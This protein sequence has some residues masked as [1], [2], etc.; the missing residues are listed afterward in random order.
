MKLNF[1]FKII[2][3]ILFLLPKS[4]YSINPPIITA[5]GNQNYCAGTS[6]KIVETISIVNDPS[7]TDAEAIYIQISSGYIN[8]QDELKLANY[9]AHPKIITSW[10]S[11]AGK[12]KL[13]S[14]SGTKILYT[15]FVSAIKDIEYSNSSIAPSGIRNFSITIGQ[16]NYLPSTGHYYQFIKSI[17]ISWTDAKIAA[18]ANPYYGLKGYLATLLTLEEAKLSGEQSSGAGWIGGS[19]AATEGIWKWVTGPE[20]GTIFWNGTGDGSTPNFAYWN[21][22]GNEPNN[23]G[24]EDYAHITA[25]GVGTPGSWNDL[26]NTGSTSGDYQPKGYI[27]EYGGMPG[28]PIL[29]IS[30]STTI[31]I[32]RI[33]S[34]T[35][36]SICNSG[37][38]TLQAT[39]S[40]GNVYWYT[41]KAGGM[42]IATGNSYSTP[43]LSTT[44]FYYV[45]A[46]NGN[47]LNSTRT[48][49]IATVKPAPTITG[50]T[51]SSVC[52]SG[53]ATLGATASEGIINWYNVS[54]GGTIMSTGTSFVTPSISTTTTYYAEVNANGCISLSRTPIIATVNKSPTISTTTAAAR[55][56]SGS[57]TL[58]ATATAGTVHW[59]DLATDG[60]LLFDG[61]SF[62]TPNINATTTYYAEAISNGCASARVPVIATIY[63]ISTATQEIILCQGENT[64]LDA[65]IPNMNYL[66]SPSGETTQTITVSAIGDY[67]VSISS[68]TIISCD[69]KKK[70]S[71]IEHLQPSI[72]SITVIENS[73]A[74]DLVKQE[75]YYEYSINGID[76][77]GSNQ[78]SYIPTGQ[79]TAYVR[80]NNGCN[81]V[82]QEFTIFT[83]PKFFTPN[84]DGFNDVWKIIEMIDYPSSSAQIFD[85][86]GKLIIELKFNN[87]SWDGKYN[88][89][90]LPA[91][92]YW[93]RLK[94]ENNKPEMKGHFTL[95]R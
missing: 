78:F 11:A 61:S 15:D 95:K 86:Y 51:P 54:T 93:Y 21:K 16:A 6:L 49:I 43:P 72:N 74:I 8:G 79:Y 77:Q 7:E 10:D 30:A 36:N 41:A 84:N 18:E 39:A 85:R 89:E 53:I 75:S 76:F 62:S 40:N 31:I 59:Y 24:D 9:T 25:L 48:E 26:S 90:L 94:L 68:P 1:F 73:I 64:T 32:P 67:N 83:I 23:A 22:A 91:D 69:S 82:T 27:V 4:S 87:N 45:E 5:T 58:K 33:E 60:N 55:C 28:D 12:L 29:K 14:P 19:D 71:V 70:I 88:S 66:W 92:D 34:T 50:L 3:G 81:L 20:A 2:L 44:T 46:T 37:R 38:V 35:P 63:P 52:N 42:S 17:G 47:C 57:V 56:D 80:E 65:S 13:Y